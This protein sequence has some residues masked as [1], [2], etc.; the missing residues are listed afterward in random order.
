MEEHKKG[1][2]FG[3]ALKHA[4]TKGIQDYGED[5]EERKVFVNENEHLFAGV[6][7]VGMFSY[8]ESTLGAGWIKRHGGNHDR[9]LNCLRIIRNAFVHENSNIEALNSTDEND[10]SAVKSYIEDLS[11]GRIEDDKKNTFPPYVTISEDNFIT[12]NSKSLDVF[13]G[14]IRAISH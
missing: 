6:M 1:Y 11:E 12:L 8:L 4:L 5:T 3:S 13:N 7:L 2:H 14:F 9:D 10:I